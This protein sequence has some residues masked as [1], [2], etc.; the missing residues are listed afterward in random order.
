MRR[1]RVEPAVRPTPIKAP[2][3]ADAISFSHASTTLKHKIFI[4]F[5]TFYY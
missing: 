4:E 1:L 5:F 2:N 3:I